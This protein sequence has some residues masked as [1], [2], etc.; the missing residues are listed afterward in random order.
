MLRVF[1][2]REERYFLLFPLLLVPFVLVSAFVGGI[3]FWGTHI[4]MLLS[5]ICSVLFLNTVHVIFTIEMMISLPEFVAFRKRNDARR[6]VGLWAEIAL[7]YLSLVIYF[8]WGMSWID[9]NL[10]V[11]L[12]AAVYILGIYYHGIRQVEGL[13]VVYDQLLVRTKP[14]MASRLANERRREKRGYQLL[15]GMMAVLALAIVIL[16]KRFEGNLRISFFVISAIVGLL[17]FLQTLR[18]HPL[19]ESNKSIFLL[20]LFFF[21]L[22]MIDPASSF[23]LLAFHGVEYLFVY[24]K[25]HRNSQTQGKALSKAFLIIAIP[26]CIVFLM[27]RTDG[28]LI[29]LVD[30]SVRNEY[31]ILKVM[32]IL[33]VAMTFVHFYIDARIYNM[34]N[35]DVRETIG[36]LL[37]GKAE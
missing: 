8:L 17:V 5:F 13:G 15:V 36:P 2:Q 19:K 34:R 23:A 26:L 3:E 24:R 21:P 20:R 11:G 28:G 33:S 25:I 18:S 35:A 32:A 12:G 7:V 16:D 1:P 10:W 14:E 22:S 29:W 9:V 6:A 4:E 37:L 30:Q 31:P 27:P